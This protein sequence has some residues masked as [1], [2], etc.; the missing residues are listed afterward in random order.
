MGLTLIGSNLIEPPSTS[1]LG[2][3]WFK[4][5]VWWCWLN[6]P[7]CWSRYHQKC[8]VQSKSWSSYHQRI[9]YVQAETKLF[10]HCRIKNAQGFTEALNTTEEAG[11]SPA[12]FT[13]ERQMG[14]G[15]DHC[16]YHVSPLCHQFMQ[17]TDKYS[18]ESQLSFHMAFAPTFAWPLQKHVGPP[19]DG[20]EVMWRRIRWF[21]GCRR[22]MGWM[23]WL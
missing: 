14:F 22:F 17:N 15:Y 5:H 9:W 3:L 7:S 10:S 11:D 12:H 1:W 2:Y 19:I 16:M 4:G 6:L 18:Q 21:P 13:W 8:E 20:L 23:E